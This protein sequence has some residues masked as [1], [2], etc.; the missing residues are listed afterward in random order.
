MPLN[1]NAEMEILGTRTVVTYKMI[2][3]IRNENKPMVTK[4]SGN[5]IILKIGFKIKN[6]IEM[7][8]PPIIY[9]E[10]PPTT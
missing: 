5:E 9:V 7:T 4:L 3:L 1:V 6:K 8:I 2:A 10:T